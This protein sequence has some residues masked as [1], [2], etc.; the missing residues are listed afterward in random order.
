[1]K[2]TKLVGSSWEKDKILWGGCE[3]VI[4]LIYKCSYVLLWKS[5][6]NWFCLYQILPPTDFLVQAI[7]VGV[8]TT[9]FGAVGLCIFRLM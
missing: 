5:R 7:D 6:S 2:L 9:L 4:V 1:M 3:F 8:K